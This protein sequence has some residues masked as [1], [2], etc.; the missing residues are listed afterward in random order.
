MVSWLKDAVFYEIYPQSFKDSNRDGI[1]DINGIVEKLDYIRDLGCNAIWINPC[2]ESPFKDAGYDVIDYK[3]VA[4]RYG[5]NNDLYRLFYEAHQKGIHV[6]LDLVAGHTSEEHPWFK[7]SQKEE[8]N[9]L[10]D[11]YIWTDDCFRGGDGLPYVAGVAEKNATYIINFFKCQPALNYGFLN[12]SKEWQK[13]IDSPECIHTRDAMVDVIRFWL[14]HG[15]DGFRVDMA[16]SLV[17]KDDDNK[18]GT[19]AVWNYI[20]DIIR[21]EY[22]DAAFVSEWNNPI[23]SSKA[24]FDMDFLLNE[25]HDGY[26]TLLRDYGNHKDCDNSFFKKDADGDITLF[27]DEYMKY[28]TY[29]KGKSYISMITGNHDTK[30]AKLTL[31]DQELK[32]A[33]AMILTMPG[34]P[35]IYYGD[36]IGMRY[37]SI[38]TKE[39]GYYRTGSRTPM[40]WDSTENHGFSEGCNDAL[41]L[42]TD[43]SADAPTVENQSADPN[44]LLNTVK[45]ILALRHN[46]DSLKADSDFEVVYAEKKKVPFIYRRGELLAVVNPSMLRAEAVIPYSTFKEKLFLIGDADIRGNKAAVL[47]QS[48][49]LFR[50]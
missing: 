28:Y 9:S 30:R 36:E 7:E 3:K 37:L 8:K 43:D 45:H 42:P 22:P 34:V 38:S 18:T 13:P 39:G 46:C 31:S 19:I 1:G 25:K 11:R 5:T 24:G 40:Q 4:P 12:P 32:I 47:P 27:L 26:T 50:I 2:F 49:A 29:T 10:T 16:N 41:Y 48:F 6:L 23:Q 21:K 35:Y 44:S 20:F 14:A 33:Y 17:K 15:A